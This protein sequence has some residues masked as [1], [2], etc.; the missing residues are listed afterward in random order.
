M[1]AIPWRSCGRAAARSPALSRSEQAFRRV[2]SIPGIAKALAG[3][4]PIAVGT[5]ERLETVFVALIPAVR[6]GE[7]D[8]LL[9]SS[10]GATDGAAAKGKK[11][12]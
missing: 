6:A 7:L 10:T 5:V 12:G 11:A 8:A 2:P 1:K 9:A 3:Q 4:T